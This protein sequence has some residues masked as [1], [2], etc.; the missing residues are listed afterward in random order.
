[1][2][3]WNCSYPTQKDKRLCCW[4]SCAER[5]QHPTQTYSV[6]W[7][8]YH[9]A[10]RIV[11]LLQPPTWIDSFR[12]CKDWVPSGALA[13]GNALWPF[14][15]TRCRR[16]RNRFWL[17][18]S[19]PWSDRFWHSLC[20]NFCT[21]HNSPIETR[22]TSIESHPEWCMTVGWRQTTLDRIPAHHVT[23]ITRMPPW[24]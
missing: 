23:G 9:S 13:W 10:H 24:R 7:S 3:S 18:D 6:G 20:C 5:S 17:W 21:W 2:V 16:Y 4:P 1:M 8:K 19:N 14:Q 15:G 11:N 12:T 22:T